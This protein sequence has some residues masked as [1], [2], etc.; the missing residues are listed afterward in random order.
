M[1]GGETLPPYG[2][3]AK[4]YTVRIGQWKSHNAET[5]VSMEPVMQHY[6]AWLTGIGAEI[7]HVFPFLKPQIFLFANRK[8]EFFFKFFWFSGA[9]KML[10]VA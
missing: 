7:K 1:S 9:D 6:S 4:R 10:R 8:P 3:L 2:R 5:I